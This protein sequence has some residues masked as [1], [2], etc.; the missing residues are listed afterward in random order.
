MPDPST[1]CVFCSLLSAPHL[2]LIAENSFAIA[3]P[4]AVP[5]AKG[6]TLVISRKHA[7]EPFALPLAEFLGISELTWKVQSILRNHYGPDG[8]NIGV[9]AGEAAGQ[10]VMH[11]HIHI[12]P[13][14][15]GDQR[16]VRGGIRRLFVPGAT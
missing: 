11:A 5:V 1:T 12:I 2:E 6:H 13:R 3:V 8:F 9:N 15:V 10:V 7:P 4:D 14:Y 16:K